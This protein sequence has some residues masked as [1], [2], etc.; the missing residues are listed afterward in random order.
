MTVAK[1]KIVDDVKLADLR[2]PRSLITPFICTDA[3]E[4][5]A[6]RGDI[7][8]LVR[9]GEELTLPVLPRSA[10]VDYIPSQYLCELIKKGGFDGVIYRSSVG[11][12]INLALFY[13]TK[14]E[15]V[16]CMP[17]KVQHV[18]VDA[19]PVGK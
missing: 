4:I 17:Y 13:P 7:E 19:K 8:F 3:E 12:E 5:A 10:A 15:G 16:R 2:S 6:L 14:A 1:F 18:S 9:L 11:D